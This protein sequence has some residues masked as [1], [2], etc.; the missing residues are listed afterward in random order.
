MLNGEGEQD[1]YELITE[2]ELS[3]SA[4][5]YYAYQEGIYVGMLTEGTGT[6]ETEVL[7]TPE[8]MIKLRLPKGKIVLSHSPRQSILMC[9]TV[10]PGPG[11][12]SGCRKLPT[13]HHVGTREK[14][15]QPS[16]R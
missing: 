1:G 10:I 4:T 9:S 13:K 8:E 12:V 11:F 15:A 14:H 7:G 6:T 16:S 2:G 5:W 3:G